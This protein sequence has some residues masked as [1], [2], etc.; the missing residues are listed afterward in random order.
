MSIAQLSRY[1]QN[2]NPFISELHKHKTKFW[3]SL[4]HLTLF[5]NR[6]VWVRWRH[7]LKVTANFISVGKN[8]KTSVREKPGKKI[9]RLVFPTQLVTIK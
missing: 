5:M 7:V 2:I 8:Q 1:T 6:C 9:K 3:A 4:L